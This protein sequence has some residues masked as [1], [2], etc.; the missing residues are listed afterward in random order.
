M[1]KQALNVVVVGCLLASGVVG[2]GP[3][4]VAVIAVAG[5][6]ATA[7]A[8]VVGVIWLCKNIENVSMDTEKKKLEIQ[9]I[10]DGRREVQEVDL[11]DDEVQQI[12]RT[13][14]VRLGDNVYR[15]H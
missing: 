15:V 3:E 2:C 14:K 10:H 9:G 5:G 7:I 13:G 8:P 12:Q 4:V 11:S 1:R 6:M